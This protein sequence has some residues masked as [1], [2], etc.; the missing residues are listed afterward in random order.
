MKIEKVLKTLNNDS[1]T[2]QLSVQLILSL[3]DI[4]DLVSLEEEEKLGKAILVEIR[5]VLENAPG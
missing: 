3:E 2:T 4:Q 1:F 5:K